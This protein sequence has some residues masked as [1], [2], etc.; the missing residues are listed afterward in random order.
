MLAITTNLKH[1][2]CHGSHTSEITTLKHYLHK[3][4]FV[5]TRSN[6][7]WLKNFDCIIFLLCIIDLLSDDILCNVVYA[8]DTT[9]YFACEQASDLWQQ[10]ELAS[11]L[12]SDLRDTKD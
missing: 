8:A 2:R 11:K 4:N 10:L 6:T 12:E 7:S 5:H 1:M 9:H 3:K